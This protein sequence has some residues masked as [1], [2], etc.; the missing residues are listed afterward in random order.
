LLNPFDKIN[1]FPA[2]KETSIEDSKYHIVLLQN[3]SLNYVH[4]MLTSSLK[5]VLP[6]IYCLYQKTIA[7]IKTK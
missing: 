6:L 3:L 7:R 4:T 5:N 1:G 2:K